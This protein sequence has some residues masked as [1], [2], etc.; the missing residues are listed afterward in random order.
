MAEYAFQNGV[1]CYWFGVRIVDGF[2]FEFG[3]VCGIVT[4]LEECGRSLGAVEFGQGGHSAEG[5]C[6]GVGD[7]RLGVAFAVPHAGFAVFGR[8]QAAA[9]DFD[10]GRILVADAGPLRCLRGYGDEQGGGQGKERSSLGHDDSRG[11]VVKGRDGAL[12]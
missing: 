5:K 9:I 8:G 12:C 1:R 11:G 10:T 2:G 6:A 3:T 4:A 7:F